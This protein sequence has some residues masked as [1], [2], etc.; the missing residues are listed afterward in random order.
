MSNMKYV[1]RELFN[2][3]VMKALLCHPGLAYDTKQ[4]LKKYNKKR[5]NGNCVETIYDF[6]KEFQANKQGR[7]YVEGLIGLQGFERDVRNA[8]A[9]DL[10]FDVDMENAHCTILMQI[11]KV[12]GWICDKLTKYVE[13]REHILN[14]VM[15]HYGA[16]RNDAK[17]LMIRMMFLGCPESWISETNITE[18]METSMDFI[19]DFKNEL[20]TI[21][22]NVWGSYPCIA[23][24]V[25]K[26]RK[27]TEVQKL[28][29]CLSIVLQSEEHKILMAVDEA[30]TQQ[31][32]SMDT[33]IF[34]GGLVRK[35]EGETELNENILRKCEQDVQDTTGYNIKLVVKP[36]E[37]TLEVGND[38]GK[39]MV[40]PGVVIDDVYAGK[41]F[42]KLMGNNMV[43][44]DKS[45]FVFNEHQGL[46]TDDNVHLRRCVNLFENELKFHQ[47]DLDT[48]KI[49]LYNYSGNE[50]NIVNMLKNVPMF[51]VYDDFFYTKA[52]T[53]QGKLLFSDGIYDFD[54]D[55]FT[56]G[57]NPLIVF[58]YRIDRPFP[59]ERNNDMI[60]E[61]TKILFEDTFMDHEMEASHYMRKGISRSLYG[62][63]RAKKFYF[64]IGKSN[65]GKSALTDAL[66]IAFGGFVGS[67]NAGALAYNE[68]NGADAA[69]QLSWV[70]GIK[71]KR[72][73]ISNEVSMNKPFDGNILKMLASGGDE[74]DARTCHKDEVKIINRSTM[75]CFVNDIPTINPN[76]DGVRNRVNCIE[77]NCVFTEDA[78][79]QDFE[80]VADKEIKDKFKHN[81]AYQDALVHII[82][83]TFKE[84]QKEGHHTPDIVKVATKEWSGD[85]G[86]VESL[87]NKRYE[88]TRD[89]ND[90]VPA[91]EILDFLIKTEKL[92]MSETKIGRELSGLKLMKE[93]KKIK[94]KT[95]RVWCGLSERVEECM[96]TYEDDY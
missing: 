38:D 23:E 70:F 19:S 31:G 96:I 44:T 41:E 91:R 61:V 10:Y 51:C 12:K 90:F 26:K 66:K 95:T 69:K 86:S 28:A 88:I 47:M 67:F 40:E 46:W 50:K 34:D 22:R 89:M 79:L 2:P 45:L 60:R 30:M 82:L 62:E 32:R 83:D 84:V 94:G 35:H 20:Y 3:T 64:C 87:L 74:F 75:F 43:Y 33:F 24:I 9:N 37:T 81:V 6:S 53:S 55:T 13:N 85:T 57:F 59:K 52:D 14:D 1:K 25:G 73:V 17:N 8:L 54:T 80:R 39:V 42:A 29:S 11:C 58:K 48:G 27:I 78:V 21:A 56:E 7:V 36:M 93:I 4:Q 49:K 76:D 92:T 77:Y 5:F 72:M 68:R 16:S 71:D 15:Q 65:A 18:T 63:Y